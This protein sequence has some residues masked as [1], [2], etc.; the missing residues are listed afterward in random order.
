MIARWSLLLTRLSFIL[1]SPA[2]LAQIVTD[3]TV[4]PA[5]TLSGPEMTIG[6]ELG[7]TRGANLFHSFQRFDISTGHRAT[8]NG[9]DQIQNVIGRVTGGT[10]SNIDGTLRSSVGQADV[11]LINPAGVVMGPN[12]KVDVPAALHLS[13]ADELRFSDGSRYSAT[14]PVGSTLSL[15]A[16]E[17]FGFLSPQP[18]SLTI[19][20]SQLALKP[21]KTT[22]LTAGDI[23]IAGSSDE[24]PALIRVPGGT[25]RIEAVGSEGARVSVDDPSGFPGGGTLTLTHAQI[26][27]SDDGGGGIVVRAGSAQ[28]TASRLSADNLGDA[29]PMGV[30][31]LAL[32]E[33]FS[34]SASRV[35][36]NIF[37]GGNA[38]AIKIQAGTIRLD[39]QDLA[40]HQ[41]GI[42]SDAHPGSTGHAGA[43]DLRVTDRLEILH[44]AKIS[45]STSAS[46]N[47]GAVA[48]RTQDMHLDGGG[49]DDPF[50]GITTSAY[51]TSTGK[52][53]DIDLAVTGRLEILNGA[54]ISSS[55]FAS[56]DAGKIRVQAGEMRLDGGGLLDQFTDLGIKAHAGSSGNAGT[57]DLKVTGL[58]EILN[59]AFISSNTWGRG[60]AGRVMIR[61]GEM[62]LDNGGLPKYT[63][64][65]S[66]AHPESNE[67]DAGTLDVTV[68]GLLEILNGATI[69]S[70]TFSSGDAGAIRIQAGT[71]RLDGQGFA[72]HK[73]GIAS[74]AYPGSTGHAGAI[75]LRVTDRLEIL[76]GAKISSS[77]SASGN[78]GAVAIRTQDMHLDGGGFDDPFT[79]IT[80]SAY[81]TSTGKAGDIDLA[82]TG[83]LEILN[84]AGIS[85]S[86]FASGDAG[87]IRVQAGEMRLDG[88][89]LLDQF[90][91][92]GINAH[93]GSSG[94][95]GTLDLT[96]TGLLE[97]LNGAFISSNTWGRGNAGKVM[98]RAGEMRLDN[99]G[100]SEY[101]GIASDA[102]PESSGGDAGTLDVMVTGLFQILN[103]ATIGSS[104]FASG[105]AGKIRIQATDLLIAGPNSGAFSQ[106]HSTSTGQVGELSIDANTLTLRDGG[107][108]SI[109][110]RQTLLDPTPPDSHLAIHTDQLTM[111][112]GIITAQSEGNV[113]AAAIDLNG[114][115]MH[116]IN[117]SEIS[118]ESL[119]T[120]AGY[121]TIGGGS[122]WLTDSLITTSA[123]GVN[124]DG[125]DITL[126]PKYLILNG[127]FIQANTAATDA[128]GGDILI[129]TCVLIASQGLVE[130]G[131]AA[132]QTFIT[133]NGRNIIQ[134]AAPGGEQGTISVTSP[135]L[136]ITAALTPL[137]SPFVDPDELFT[138]LCRT[139]NETGTSSLVERGY[140]G[141]PVDP[142]APNSISFTTERLDRLNT[143]SPGVLE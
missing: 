41:T 7:A 130:I 31:D 32:S 115:E 141:L 18:A 62:R 102:H 65:A 36:S 80:T 79:G 54:G 112:G 135:N 19:M 138:N 122:L 13:T 48:I 114:L 86:T 28:L 60:N 2:V 23:T 131:G 22:T 82:V 81:A 39:G 1:G 47:A 123:E 129:N 53:G 56:G 124:G 142:G 51:A 96:V 25:L 84:G 110:A 94:N 126:T 44:G 109:K 105:D 11:Y 139:L 103:G 24:Q 106:A 107:T 137:A 143:A 8:F 15:A 26:D 12:A 10:A 93:A 119:A 57:L 104:T 55:T 68:T 50:T 128:R 29:P 91:D 76:H 78:A 45:S 33:T 89:G 125:G 70:S 83:R 14:D 95:A 75:D 21:G 40:H 20:G 43:I 99:G 37:V 72:R 67:G 46:G 3:G 52:A 121:I 134:A 85:S 71:M 42:S 101:T 100:R 97:I 132:R 116:L 64:I 77:T 120:D 16:P 38:G 111:D 133:N 61:A 58:L 9:P 118:T 117:S 140:G 74:D 73:T 113:P 59:G 17:S 5:T 108:L 4:G 27:A 35:H 30:V 69:G 90:T 136:D 87:K 49:F 127:G 98:I 6:A 34:L 88:G 66:D 92:L 63:G